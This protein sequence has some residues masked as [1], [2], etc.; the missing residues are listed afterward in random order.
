M[1]VA[2]RRRPRFGCGCR[3]FRVAA[4]LGY[5]LFEGVSPGVMAGVSAVAAGAIMAMLVETMI[6]E[7]FEGTRHLAGLEACLGFLVSFAITVLAE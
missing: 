2:L 3:L 7:A 4:F 5:T 1:G 6:P